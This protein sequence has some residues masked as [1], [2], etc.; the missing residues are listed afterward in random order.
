MVI[1]DRFFCVFIGMV[2]KLVDIVREEIVLVWM[3]IGRLVVLF[4]Y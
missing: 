4:L 3:V 1:I 2:E